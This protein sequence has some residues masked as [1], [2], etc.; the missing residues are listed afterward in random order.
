[1][2]SPSYLLLL[3]KIGTWYMDIFGERVLS[4][5]DSKTLQLSNLAS[6]DRRGT[7]C[8]PEC[9]HSEKQVLLTRVNKVN[10]SIAFY[11]KLFIV[12]DGL[13]A[14]DC[15]YTCYVLEANEILKN[16]KNVNCQ[17]GW[18]PDQETKVLITN[19]IK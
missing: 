3:Q 18:W 9:G 8:H 11:L 14:D 12:E 13:F 2:I 19:H 1:M 4:L 16:G 5:D 10:I 17:R 7:L 15:C 6:R